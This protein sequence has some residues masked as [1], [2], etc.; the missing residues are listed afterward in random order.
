MR[1]PTDRIDTFI[2]QMPSTNP[3]VSNRIGRF[4]VVTLLTLLATVPTARSESPTPLRRTYDL[5]DMDQSVSPCQ[6]FYRYANGGWLSKN[7][8]PP[9]ESRC[10]S[11]TW[12]AKRNLGLIRKIMEEA[13]A[14]TTGRD[15]I[16]QIVGDFWY[17]GMDARAIEEQGLKPL[18]PEFAKID[19]IKDVKGLIAE[20]AILH[21]MGVDVLF[22]Y[23]STQDAKDGTHVT[24]NACQGGLGLSDRDDYTRTDDASEKLRRQ[25][26][27]YVEKMLTLIGDDKAKA[28]NGAATIMELE[29]RLAKASMTTI[30][31]RQPEA[32]YHRMSTAELNRLTPGLPWVEYFAALGFPAIGGVNVEQ[33]SFFKEVEKALEAIPLDDWKIYLRYHLIDRAAPFLC[34]RF[35]NAWFEFRGKILTG[36]KEIPPRWKRVITDS[37]LLIGEA[38]G[39]K[40]VKQNFSPKAREKAKE[41]V[42][43]LRRSLQ[44]Q[45]QSTNWM[46]PSTRR[47]ALAK[48]EAFSEKIGYPDKWWDYTELKLDRGPYV[49][50]VFRCLVFQKRKDLAKI[51]KPFDR[52]EWIVE[53]QRVDAYYNPQRNEIIFPAGILQPPLFDP[54]APD[55]VNL[56]G[57]GAVIGHEMGHGFD[58]QGAKYDAKGNMVNWWTPVDLEYFRKRCLCIS[59]QFDKYVLPGGLRLQGKLV[60]GEAI[61]DL[62]GLTLAYRTLERLLKGKPHDRDSQGFTPEQRFFLAFSKLWAGHER[63]EFLRRFVRTD[64]HPPYQFRV[65]GTVANMPEFRKA[66]GCQEGDPIARPTGEVCSPW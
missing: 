41:M 26:V 62:N 21:L 2:D 23:F 45:I 16:E 27:V 37:S 55:A 59:N 64:P 48:L 7:P 9:D 51:D 60:V 52:T 30:D 38:V 20:T 56:G 6:D 40:F 34:D 29:T 10:C 32:V 19:G 31:R 8:I 12:M 18:A 65:N 50:N 63:P 46:E 5:A 33:P 47:Q 25:Y 39:Q 1:I 11:L 14:R 53:P 13:A 4:A 61:S 58:D 28:H 43:H 24:G 57:I 49:C 17:S 54:E 15:H 36:Q 35:N 42:R 3:A 22:N 66:F 44:D